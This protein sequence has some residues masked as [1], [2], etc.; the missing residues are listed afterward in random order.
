MN[1]TRFE[2]AIAA[3]D[4][5]H[6]QDPRKE[7]VNGEERP[8][9]LVYAER[10]TQ[11]LRAFHPDPTE[12][13]QLAARAQHLGRWKLDRKD[14]SMDV[15]GYNLWRSK[16]KK[17]HADDA[18]EILTELGYDATTIQEVQDLILKKQFKTRPQAQILED[19]I[20]L[21]FLAHY[22]EDFSKDHTDEKIIGIV[23]KTWQKMSEKGH[24]AVGQISLSPRLAELVGKA[25][26]G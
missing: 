26:A 16:L 10:M 20:C 12:A 1:N 21:T 19:V 6:Q 5:I 9:E 15:K 4:E 3:F 24:E 14:F 8:K 17:M 25:L 22:F 23:Q 11:W 18:G 7:L 2:K 13:L